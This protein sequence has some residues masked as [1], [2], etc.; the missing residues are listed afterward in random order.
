[1]I[2]TLVSCTHSGVYLAALSLSAWKAS[3]SKSSPNIYLISWVLD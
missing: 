1:V 3:N 2:I